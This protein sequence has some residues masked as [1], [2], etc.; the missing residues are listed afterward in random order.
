MFSALQSM[1]R[2]PN[3]SSEPW[4]I[5]EDKALL[6]HLWAGGKQTQF[7]TKR[8]ITAVKFR[9]LTL[10]QHLRK[11]LTDAIVSI[12]LPAKG[13]KSNMI[14]ELASIC[15]AEA[16]AGAVSRQDAQRTLRDCAAQLCNGSARWE[17]HVTQHSGAL[18]VP[19][20]WRLADDSLAPMPLTYEWTPLV[21]RKHGPIP[22]AAEICDVTLRVRIPNKWELVLNESRVVLS[23]D[24]LG[25]RVL[26]HSTL[27]VSDVQRDTSIETI[28]NAV[29]V[30]LGKQAAVHN[31]RDNQLRLVHVSKSEAGDVF[32]ELPMQLTAQ[33]TDLFNK[34]PGLIVT[35]LPLAASPA[36]STAAITAAPTDAPIAAPTAAPT[37]RMLALADWDINAARQNAAQACQT[38]LRILGTC[39][40]PFPRTTPNPSLSAVCSASGSVQCSARRAGAPGHAQQPARARQHFKRCPL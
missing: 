38:C 9:V 13:F 15:Q 4:T 22:V 17:R 34:A 3:G 1:D 30:W 33:Q 27:R 32:E 39:L 29:G 28:V 11:R 35:T 21:A 8:T 36:S 23:D 14:K 10:R 2:C 19:F 37:P 7:E 26:G 40:S 25:L 31:L 18:S 6:H 24:E 16:E 12:A 5:E 20:P